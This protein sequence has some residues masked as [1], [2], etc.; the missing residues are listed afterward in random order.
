M[1]S[2]LRKKLFKKTK[3]KSEGEP[4]EKVRKVSFV[5]PCDPTIIDVVLGGD[6]EHDGG[7]VK[8][9]SVESQEQVDDKKAEDDVEHKEGGGEV[10]SIEDIKEEKPHHFLRYTDTIR[11]SRDSPKLQR[12]VSRNNSTIVSDDE[13]EKKEERCRY[14]CDA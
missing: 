8:E 4:V 14:G 1:I 12:M 6:D 13:E 10:K 2:T 3:D 7:P 11:R 9:P 5:S